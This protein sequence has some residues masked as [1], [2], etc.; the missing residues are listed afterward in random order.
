MN[1]FFRFV[2]LVLVF[3][4]AV[5]SSANPTARDHEPGDFH[6]R[7]EE[8]PSTVHGK[9]TS[10]P[11]NV[12]NVLDIIKQNPAI[13]ENASNELRTNYRIFLDDTNGNWSK[14]YASVLFQVLS[15]IPQSD[16]VDSSYWVLVDEFI[17]DDIEVEADRD[18]TIVWISK[19]AFE[20]A[21]P[22][23][24][25]IGKDTGI[26]FSRRLHHALV[27]YVTNNGQNQAAYEKILIENFGVSTTV[28]NYKALTASTTH[29][30]GHH[31][32]DFH[33]SE[34]IEIISM[35][36]EMPAAMHKVAGLKFLIRRLDGTSHPVYGDIPAVAWTKAGYIEFTESA[37][38]T[39]HLASLRRLIIH[40]KSHFLWRNVVDSA[41]TADWITLGGWHADKKD[42]DGWTTDNQTQ[43]VSAYAHRKNPNEHLAESIAYYILNPDLLR[44]RAMGSFE[45]IRDRIMQGDIYVSGIR[46]DLT[47]NVK[48]LTPDYSIPGKIQSVD[49]RVNGAPDEDKRVTILLSLYPGDPTNNGASR[50]YTRVTSEIGTYFDL[51][52][53]PVNSAGSRVNV[54]TQLKGEIRLSK[55]S[56]KGYWSTHQIVITDPVGNSRFESANDF[57]WNLYIDSPLQDL[58]APHYI[59]GTAK[60][61]RSL[62]AFDGETIQVIYANWKVTENNEMGGYQC[63][64]SLND[65]HAETYRRESYGHYDANTQTCSAAFKM[66][67]YMPS[68]IYYLTEIKM[69]DMALNSRRVTF[70]K[71]ASEVPDINLQTNNPDLLAPVL[72][73]NHIRLVS[74]S[75]NIQSPNGE[76]LVTIKFR[77]NDDNSGFDLAALRLRDP[78]GVEHFFSYVRSS[79]NKVVE[80]NEAVVW[81]EFT[82]TVLLPTGSVPGTWGLSEVSVRDKAGNFKHNIFTELVH[83]N[84]D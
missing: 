80:D 8:Q 16:N 83:F 27:R 63:Y 26:A 29:E 24:A 84:V 11:H 10:R 68:G 12:L 64:A 57:G 36:D 50:A 43:F 28:D 15:S 49:I 41:I 22:S 53:Y 78:G 4:T 34:I 77:V 5:A 59:E 2:L 60:L 74:E 56:K 7:W 51:H 35:L 58:E 69:S 72:D 61:T 17:A 70:L 45:F 40:E 54:G 52:L 23:Q 42:P 47:F 39:D 13:N 66:P 62:V 33:P 1:L 18:Y 46:Q 75:S 44:S 19:A 30:D 73:V 32:Q 81:Q 65:E 9:E 71:G 79:V 76:T 48:N 20:R 21:S 3:C 38:N 31:F 82:D 25:S 55:Y 67:E 6:F 14:E 37:F